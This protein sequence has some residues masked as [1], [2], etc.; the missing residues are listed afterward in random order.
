VVGIVSE[1]D[2]ARKVVLLGTTS[3]ET[4]VEVIMTPASHMITI[5]P[6]TSLEACMALM[7]IHHIRH[8]PVLANERLIGII[9]SRDVIQAVIEEN[10]GF[11]DNL[12]DISDSLFTQGFDDQLA[13]GKG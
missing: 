5:R 4:P 2:Y 10:N 9:S 11:I 8:L 13:G 7:T 1:R 6:D 12:T 3:R